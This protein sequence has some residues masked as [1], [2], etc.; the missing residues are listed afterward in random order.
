[1]IEQLHL[2]LQKFVAR[3]LFVKIAVRLLSVGKVGKFPYGFVHGVTINLAVSVSER[4][5]YTQD[6]PESV[7]IHRH[8]CWCSAGVSSDPVGDGLD[9]AAIFSAAQTWRGKECGVRM[10]SRIDRR[11][12]NSVPL[13][14]LPLRNYLFDLRRRGSFSC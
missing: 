1:M 6:G 8:F 11:R 14:V 3:Q 4:I 10:R 2:N 13:A 9:V 5:W 7:C 12:A